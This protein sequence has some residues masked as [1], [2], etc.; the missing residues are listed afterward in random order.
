MKLGA[1]YGYWTK[2]PQTDIVPT[3]VEAE[4]LG[5]DSIWTGE[6]YSSDAFTPLAWVGAHTERIKLITGIAQLGARTP[7]SLAMQAMTLDGLS[8]GRFCLGIGV[9]GPQVIEGWYGQ[10]FGKPLARTRETINI[11]RDIWERENPVVSKGPFFPLPYPSSAPNSWGLG[12]PLKLITEPLRSEIPILLGAEGPKNISLAFEKCQGWIPLYYSPARPEI[13]E[14]PELEVNDGFEIAVNVT[15]NICE[16]VT[17]GLLPQKA[18]LAFYIGGM[19]AQK[20]NFHTELMARMGYEG[21][22]HEIQ[23][24]FLSGKRDEAIMAV[25]DD[26]ADEISLVGPIER[27]AERLELWKESP[28]TTLIIGA[29]DVYTM[30]AMAELVL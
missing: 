17:A 19:G 24:L 1:Q 26:F 25:P 22:A 7:A 30:R 5:F 11:L 23:N 9:S 13:Y 6:S 8:G 2:K 16:D 14:V 4:N 10:P 21:E 20:R 27:I 18:I 29:S 28:V 3:A 15:V 12:K